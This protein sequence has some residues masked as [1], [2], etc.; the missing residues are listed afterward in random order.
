VKRW[1]A[2][3]LL[4]PL[5]CASGGGGTFQVADLPVAPM[6]L[7]YRTSEE[8]EKV[9]KQLDARR[10][11]QAQDKAKEIQ[12]ARPAINSV[13]AIREAFKAR[14]EEAGGIDL[15]ARLALYTASTAE[16][17]DAE[18]AAKG[19][20]PL[21]WSLDH[22]RLLFLAERGAETQLVEWNRQTDALLQITSG[23]DPVL[24]GC[25]GP[26]GE[27]AYSLGTH[28]ENTPQGAAGG[29]RI[30]AR[31]PGEEPKPVTP[32]PMDVEPAW[33]PKEPL[34]VYQQRA[35]DGLEDIVSVNPFAP[36][37]PH[38]L[39]RGRSPVFT[40]DGAWVIYSSR[41][42]KGWKLFRMRPD[43]SGRVPV[44]D[45]PTQEVEPAVSP[46]G[47]FIAFIGYFPGKEHDTELYVLPAN[48]GKLRKL[49]FD[50]KPH[51]VTW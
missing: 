21:A 33:S 26:K 14:A 4:L 45:G 3:G 17:Q 13:E 32:G 1:S 30:F 47:R 9:Q 22:Q 39:A 37:P 7:S 43:G 34:L 12:R 38:R 10:Q 29:I 16:V 31:I 51:R 11:Q 25:Y 20:R 41:S 24:G 35:S 46:D 36:G 48:G 18:F 27:I 23:E 44:V 49:K 2:L 42:S 6:A 15:M 40:P 8:V 50:D 5:A 19:D 28:L